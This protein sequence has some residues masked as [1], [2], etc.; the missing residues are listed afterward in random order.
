MEKTAIKPT[1]GSLVRIDEPTCISMGIITYID[2]R[3]IKMSLWPDEPGWDK[4]DFSVGVG[5][6]MHTKMMTF[7]ITEDEKT[8]FLQGIID[9]KKTTVIKKLQQEIDRNYAEIEEFNA[10]LNKPKSDNI[11]YYTPDF[12]D[13]IKTRIKSTMGLVEATS[14]E[15]HRMYFWFQEMGHT[16]EQISDGIG[17]TIGTF[18]GHDIVVSLRWHKVDGVLIGFYEAES[19]VVNHNMVKEWIKTAF[20]HLKPGAIN[21]ASNSHNTLNAAGCHRTE[22]SIRKSIAHVE[23]EFKYHNEHLQKSLKIKIAEKELEAAKKS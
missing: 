16:V 10:L 12:E 18:H 5:S 20:P 13:Y 17:R 3:T 1:V 22:E 9:H 15:V 6:P 19:V 23:N 7:Y 21:N 14:E 2:E 11:V 8:K 4:T